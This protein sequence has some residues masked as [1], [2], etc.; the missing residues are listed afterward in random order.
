[1]GYNDGEC[2]SIAKTLSGLKGITKVKVLQYHRFSAS[3]Y[4]ALGMENTL[5]DTETT[6]TDVERAVEILKLYGLN[7]VNGMLED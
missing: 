6:A 3:R 1:M 4:A 7:A 2:E 5:P